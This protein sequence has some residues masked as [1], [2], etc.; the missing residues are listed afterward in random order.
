MIEIKVQVPQV[1]IDA[2]NEDEDEDN[3]GK[4]CGDYTNK[5]RTDDMDCRCPCHDYCPCHD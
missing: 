1:F 4:C 3:S 5:P 2:F